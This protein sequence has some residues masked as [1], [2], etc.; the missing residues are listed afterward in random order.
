MFCLSQIK[1]SSV[2]AAEDT[3][4]YNHTLM[5][6]VYIHFLALEKHFISAELPAASASVSDSSS[7]LAV[8]PQVKM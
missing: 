3:V 8:K 4:E 1:V 5:I 6:Y 2:S 7:G